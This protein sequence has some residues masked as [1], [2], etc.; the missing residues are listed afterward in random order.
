MTTSAFVPSCWSKGSLPPSSIT[1]RRGRLYFLLILLKPDDVQGAS[2][3]TKEIADLAV[4]WATL[5]SG[6]L[7][8]HSGLGLWGLL[9]HLPS[10]Q[11]RHPQG[12]SAEE[13]D[14]GESPEHEALEA[15]DP[16]GRAEGPLP[17]PRALLLLAVCD[18]ENSLSHHRLCHW[19]WDLPLRIHKL[20][21]ADNSGQR[22][23]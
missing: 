11:I 3:R 20:L 15:N 14:P 8:G 1:L 21:P 2:G 16:A 23:E 5:H 4:Q 18:L 9:L 22:Q 19:R 7:P 12:N 17:A 6:G 10:V 13:R